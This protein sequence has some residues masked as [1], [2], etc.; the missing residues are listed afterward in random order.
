VGD[1]LGAYYE[2]RAVE[3][4]AIY[5]KPERQG[6]LAALKRRLR[7]LFLGRRVLEIAAGTGY[8]TEHIAATAETVLATDV[9][10]A[11]LQIARR[12]L[13]TA[14]SR[15]GG[16]ASVTFQ[17]LDA[18]RLED[19]LGEFDALFAGF[20]WSH[21]G[22]AQIPHF[23]AGVANQL[24]PSSLV[25]MIDNRYVEGSN[26]PI[27]RTDEDGNT[28][29][30]RVL[31]DGSSWEVLKN[32]ASPDQLL[33]SVRPYADEASVENLTYYWLLRFTLR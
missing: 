17:L 2:R 4:D 8:W 1:T 3:Y 10:P 30:R 11:P 22:I 15:Y 13:E 5:E 32:F 20:W 6:D 19:V 18:F 16:G 28:Y 29:Q 26:H 7:E 12:R 14:N 33:H 23:L 27:T 31:S 9:S 25:V 21:M 24:S